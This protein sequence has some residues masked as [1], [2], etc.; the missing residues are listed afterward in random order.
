MSYVEVKVSELEERVRLL[1]KALNLMLMEGEELP[2]DEVEEVKSRLGDW[3]KEEKSD[4]I[5][6]EKIV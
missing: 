4:F 2:H 1:A 5:E 3:F 6:L